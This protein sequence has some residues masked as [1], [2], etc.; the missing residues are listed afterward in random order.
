MR[1]DESASGTEVRLRVGDAVEVVLPER[2]TAGFRWQV[3]SP[4]AP[5]CRLENDKYTAPPG[6]PGASGEHSWTF[7]AV[8]GGADAVALAYGRSFGDAPPVRRFE[9]RVAV[10]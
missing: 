7:R 6:P 4:G 8:Q 5:A 9:L 3:L 1:V 10:E 2:R